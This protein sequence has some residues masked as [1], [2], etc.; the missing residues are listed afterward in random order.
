MRSGCSGRS[1][2]RS[3][4][5]LLAGAAG[6]VML[7]AAG[8][9]LAQSAPSTVT[10]ASDAD[11]GSDASGPISHLSLS[12]G[13]SAWS[14]DYGAPTST[15]IRAALLNARYAMGDL[16][17]TA[18]LPYMRIKS[19]G[20][21]FTGIGATPLIVA[22]TIPM[23]Q[24]KREG[25]GDLTLGASYRLPLPPSTGFDFELTGK[26]K[27][28]TASAASGVSTGQTD[29]S[30]GGELSKPM[31][32]LVPFVSVTW[33]QFGDAPG[34]D[35]RNGVATSV[36]ASYV[37]ANRMTAV[38]SYDYAQAASRFVSDAHEIGAAVSIP[39]Y[40]DRLRLTAFGSRG[41]SKGAA[42]FSGGLSLSV[43]L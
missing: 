41:L 32:A 13:G 40:N 16:R 43:N 5:D 23:G 37:F 42:D 12:A 15:E 17:L 28:A 34:W 30:V 4:R 25:W 20:T 10:A 27:L 7:A 1:E 35:L 6:L 31:G 21:V 39:V 2:I 19:N 38:L 24:R 8:P 26:V 14:G 3:M 22:P 29:Y 36:G 33:R 18:S 11:G 9:V